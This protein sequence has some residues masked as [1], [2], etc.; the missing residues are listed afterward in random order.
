MLPALVEGVQSLLALGDRLTLQGPQPG[1]G[2]GHRRA[3]HRRHCCPSSRTTSRSPSRHQPTPYCAGEQAVAVALGPG[4]A[5]L[6]R[7]ALQGR[8]QGLGQGSAKSPLQRQQGG[9]QG[10]RI[11]LLAGCAAG[12]LQ[13]GHAGQGH[14][15]TAAGFRER[16][17]G[18]DPAEGVNKFLLQQPITPTAGP[19][20]YRLAQQH[21]A[22]VPAGEGVPVNGQ[23]VHQLGGG[24]AHLQQHRGGEL[25]QQGQGRRVVLAG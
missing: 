15:H 5:P 23:Q 18:Q 10:R 7:A 3:P 22:R 16:G 20:Q 9:K 13:L 12:S 11:R 6:G 2:Q 25:A 4:Q 19:G 21:L 14:Q 17:V 8:C 1:P 24:P